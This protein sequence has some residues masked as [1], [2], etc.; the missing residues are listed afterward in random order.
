[1]RIIIIVV[2]LLGSLPMIFG[3]FFQLTAGAMMFNASR[4]IHADLNAAEQRGKKFKDDLDVIYHLSAR[5]NA[6]TAYLALRQPNKLAGLR[7]VSVNRRFPIKAFLE[8]GEKMPAKEFIDVLISSRATKVAMRECAV[9]QKVLADQCTVR[10]ASGKL[11]KYGRG[12]LLRASYDF[13]AKAGVGEYN[14]AVPLRFVS[15]T[16]HLKRKGTV[17]ESS[18]A[19]LY[20]KAAE[21]CGP[22]RR[23]EGNC[24]VTYVGLT[25][26]RD[27]RDLSARVSLSMLQER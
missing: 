27:G 17:T 8:R 3:G 5:K 26:G 11:D 19:I 7:T 6:Q 12:I 4:S 23:R 25:T 14:A 21:L 16:E 13:T 15:T 22:V 18:R 10:R 20:R 9:I 2:F 24:A 1:M